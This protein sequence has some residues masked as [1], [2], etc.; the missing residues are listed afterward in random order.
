MFPLGR[1]QSNPAARAALAAHKQ[2]KFWPMHD[3]IYE[4][5]GSLSDEKY[6]RFAQQIGLNVSK[7][8]TDMASPEIAAQVARDRAE[9]EKAEISGTPAIF[10]NG[11]KYMG[12]AS[13]E[14]LN[15]AIDE[16][17]AEQK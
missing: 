7:F 4:N 12:D 6:E 3:L 2:G 8:K 15:E 11:R 14:G 5:Q 10:M 16:A 13:M 17:L 1:P 9:G